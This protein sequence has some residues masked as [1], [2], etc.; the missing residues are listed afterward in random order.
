MEERVTAAERNT[1]L[2]VLIV[3]HGENERRPTYRSCPPPL[4]SCSGFVLRYA[5]FEHLGKAQMF[6]FDSCTEAD[7]KG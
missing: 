2:G 5:L 4:G 6:D 3:E 7:W 1:F